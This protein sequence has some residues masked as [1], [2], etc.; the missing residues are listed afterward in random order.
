MTEHKRLTIEEFA[1]IKQRV[2]DAKPYGHGVGTLALDDVPKLIAEVE[3][4]QA[5]I[6]D[7]ENLLS[8]A[9]DLLDDVPGYDTDVYHAITEYFNGGDDG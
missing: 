8:A 6:D 3:A 1:D 7:A 4:L 5:R 2:E 9:H